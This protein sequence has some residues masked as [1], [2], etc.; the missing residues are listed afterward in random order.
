M[1]NLFQPNLNNSNFTTTGGTMKTTPN[2]KIAAPAGSSS[3]FTKSL[4]GNYTNS[5]FNTDK[6]RQ[7]GTNT[8]TNTSTKMSL[9]EKL[10]LAITGLT[11]LSP[12]ALALINRKGG[13]E[14]TQNGGNKADGTKNGD[15]KT[16]TSGIDGAVK[17][18]KS[19]KKED[20]AAA[21]QEVK[22]QI[23]T[24]GTQKQSNIGTINKNTGTIQQDR[25]KSAEQTK[26]ISDLGTQ[27]TD[28][29]KTITGLNTQIPQTKQSI[30][31]LSTQIASYDLKISGL[32]A[33]LSGAAAADA[34]SGGN[35]AQMIQQQIDQAKEQK[36][37]AQDE[38][39]KQEAE[40]GKQE[41]SLKENQ[42]K[43]D[44]LNTQFKVAKEAKQ[45]ADDEVTK[46]TQENIDLKNDNTEFDKKIA[47]ANSAIGG[48]S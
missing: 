29:N 37:K 17:S 6:H 9:A 47:K 18:Y 33:Q 41:T 45:T 32:S 46:L 24:L 15:H 30:S 2:A 35:S 11:T 26:I 39:T 16:D 23:A 22:G 7:M 27:M 13:T 8:Q 3:A 44:K 31:T 42:E 40:L 5:I 43:L 1:S 4:Q 12:I 14:G 25:Q 19:A 38:K 20:K 34:L 21:K 28:T 48:D 10:T 36:T